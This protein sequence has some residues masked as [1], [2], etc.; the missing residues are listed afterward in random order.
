MVSS[1]NDL[2]FKDEPNKPRLGNLATHTKEHANLIARQEAEK[3]GQEGGREGQRS[4]NGG[5]TS[6][7]SSHTGF[8]LASA[9]LME[10]YVQDGLL[11]PR[12]EPTQ[13][14]FSRLFAAWLIEQDLPFTTG[15]YCLLF[16]VL[17]TY[18]GNF[19]QG[20]P[21]LSTGSLNTF[22]VDFPFHQTQPC[23]RLWHRFLL[24]FVV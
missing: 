24:T 16:P 13:S 10:K 11:N 20:N 4:E 8:M 9:K 15:M 21:S 14:G 18:T 19:E 12:V 6:T 2:R 1:R 17:S 22:N 23:A 3:N 5:L 7:N